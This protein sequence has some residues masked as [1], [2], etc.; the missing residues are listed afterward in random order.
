MPFKDK[1]K[2][3]EWEKEYTRRPEV[4]K[5]KR[6]YKQRPEV[7][8]KSKEYRQR[9]ERKE[10]E[11]ERWQRLEN[12]I[13][14]REYYQKNKEKIKIRI[15]ESDRVYRQR[16]KEKIKKRKKI[17]DKKYKA[18]PEVKAR[19]NLRQRN[20]LNK[21][22][23]FNIKMRLRASLHQALRVYTK[24]GKIMSS[25]KYGINFKSIIEHLKPFPQDLS[26]YHVDHIKPLCSFDLTNPEEVRKSFAPENHQ[27]LTAFENISKGGRY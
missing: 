15:R 19:N 13:K 17:S 27:W 12:K 16:N 25:K 18:R 9:S 14:K 20:R 24:T 6:E 22:K 2:Q 8:A 5:R 11:R 21:D 26:K 23:S 4:K 10:K 7:K 3:K 1:Q